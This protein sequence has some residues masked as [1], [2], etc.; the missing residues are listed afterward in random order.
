MAL[1]AFGLFVAIHDGWLF[2]RSQSFTLS[3]AD[4]VAKSCTARILN[5]YTM[6]MVGDKREREIYVCTLGAC[7][8]Y[9]MEETSLS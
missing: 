1:T 5:D 7:M 3:S 8:L 6:N 9:D 4:P 2:E